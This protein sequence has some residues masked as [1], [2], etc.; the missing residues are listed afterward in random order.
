MMMGRGAGGMMLVVLI[1]FRLMM[2]GW[3]GRGC[4]KGNLLGGV[5]IFTKQWEVT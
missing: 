4:M 2:I 3:H 5:H 1:G